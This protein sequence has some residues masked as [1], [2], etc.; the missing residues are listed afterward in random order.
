MRDK[1]VVRLSVTP[2]TKQSCAGSL[3]RLAKGKTT[4]DRRGAEGDEGTL[5]EWP[6]RM[7]EGVADPCVSCTAPTKLKPFRGKVL[8]RCCL[9]PSSPIAARAAFR[10]VVNAASETM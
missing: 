1:S 3:L 2:S 9:S 6:L 4:I 7:P 10:R 5:W 8:I